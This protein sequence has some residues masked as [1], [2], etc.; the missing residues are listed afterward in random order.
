M[1][2]KRRIDRETLAI[3]ALL[4]GPLF[5]P[6]A[7]ITYIVYQVAGEVGK[8]TE[9]GDLLPSPF[10]HAPLPRFIREKPEVVARIKEML[11]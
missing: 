9:P 10:P 7:A 8:I 5:G 11:S 4:G 2:N 1:E 3:I 6:G